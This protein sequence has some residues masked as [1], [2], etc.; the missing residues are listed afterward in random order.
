MNGRDWETATKRKFAAIL[1][2]AA[3]LLTGTASAAPPLVG[4]TS[5]AGDRTGYV[6]VDLTKTLLKPFS[7]EDEP[8]IK[9]EGGGA[10]LGVVLRSEWQL[11]GNRRT[12]L[13]ILRMDRRNEGSP[14]LYSVGN[15]ENGLP[16]GP[17]RLYL[18]VEKAGRVTLE[19]PS[20]PRG[21]L[22]LAPSVHTPFEAGPLPRRAW[23]TP[24]TTPYGKTGELTSDG[25]VFSRAIVEAAPAGSRMEAC[26]YRDEAEADAGDQAYGP[27]CP[28]GRAGYAD[29]ATTARDL[30]IVAFTFANSAGKVGHGGNFTTSP[31]PIASPTS[32]DTFG[33][34][35]SYEFATQPPVVPPPPVPRHGTLVFAGRRLAVKNGVA[36]VPLAC[37]PEG[38]CRGW[39][40]LSGARRKADANLPPGVQRTVKVPL[41]GSMQRRLAS[42][43]KV[44]ARIVVVSIVAD[45]RR[46]QHGR[47]TLVRVK[48]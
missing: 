18:I 33:M 6:R 26:F 44:R 2:S 28:G 15:G 1:A 4:T 45:G 11:D 12:T 8:R 30:G 46:Q 25:L 48:R 47:V 3:F 38:P 10:V 22:S 24:G 34:W 43:R 20:L 41:S 42:R 13:E 32:I 17:Y 9:L 31:P 7:D 21:Q 40:R 29:M 14:I 36:R 39:V 37:S 16:A 5:I 23:P 19:F 27:G 35:L